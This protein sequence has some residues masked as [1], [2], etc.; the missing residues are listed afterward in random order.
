[1]RTVYKVVFIVSILLNAV[2]IGTFGYL[3]ASKGHVAQASEQE[4]DDA[5][6]KEFWIVTVKL[7]VP[8]LDRQAL[9]Y[10]YLDYD[11]L[12]DFRDRVKAYSM[13]HNNMQQRARNEDE[14]QSYRKAGI[15]RNWEAAFADIQGSDMYLLTDVGAFSSSANAPSG[16]LWIVTKIGYI[17]KEP[18]CWCVP[19]QPEIGKEKVIVLNKNNMFNVAQEYDEMI[20]V[21]QEY[22]ET[23][24]PADSN[25]KD[26]VKAHRLYNRMISVFRNAKSIYYE[27]VCWSGPEGSESLRQ[28]AYRIWMK[29]PYS[30]RMEAGINNKITGT[31]A[32]DDK[33]MWIYWGDKTMTFE[34]ESF[35]KY[36]NTTYVQIPA[37][38]QHYFPVNLVQELKAGIPTLVLEPNRFYGTEHT[39]DDVLDGVRSHGTEVVNGEECDIIEASYYDNQRSHFYWISRKDHLPRKVVSVLR[40]NVNI[41]S[42]EIWSNV[43]MNMDIPDAL[44]SWSPPESW[45]QYVTPELKENLLDKGLVAPDFELKSIDGKDIRLSSYKGKV[46]LLYFWQGAVT[47]AIKQIAYFQE[48]Q[49]KYQDNGLVV[50]GINAVDDY[51]TAVGFLRK[52]RID[53]PNIV[54]ASVPA[55][56]LHYRMYQ[57]PSLWSANPMSYI[58]DREGKVYDA[59]YGF[60]EEGEESPAGRL[61]QLGFE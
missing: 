52:N 45:T 9:Q 4:I 47:P 38:K 12:P 20:T 34:G 32:G 51:R 49:N 24:Y 55:Q 37:R 25:F 16:T 36:N 48:L 57:K 54:D 23:H 6:K 42:K 21:G 14:R 15:R 43:F 8:E 7:E 19:V 29:K 53:F 1:M 61:K 13:H 56:D 40:V 41:I 28:S 18:V 35:D 11:P 59:W 60:V 17:D 50:I 3:W 44:F 46:V 27:S 26:E 58:I 10:A 31:L 5:L 2:T 33:N 39:L 30:V 22:G